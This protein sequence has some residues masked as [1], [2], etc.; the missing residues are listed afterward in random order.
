MISISEKQNCSGCHA[1]ASICPKDCIS[2]TAD[3]EGFWYP[4]VDKSKCI[5][6][7][8]CEKACSI[9]NPLSSKSNPDAYACYNKDDEIRMQSSSGGVFTLFAEYVIQQGGVLFGAVFDDDFNVIHSFIGK[10]QDLYKFRC[11]KYVQSKIGG[12]YSQAKDF[13]E[14]GKKVLFTG[15]PCQ[16]A[17]LKAY[18]S[19][20]YVNLICQDI[21]CHGVPSPKVWG[22]YLSE[23]EKRQQSSAK[24]I[25]FRNKQDGWQNYKLSISFKN[26][27]TYMKPK[28]SY[29]MAFL[30]NISLRPSCYACEFKTLN[31]LS[32][33]T[34]ADFWGIK[35]IMPEMFDDK[36]VSLVLI[37]SDKGEAVFK[38]IS[39]K[40]V[41]K[42][43]N[44]NEA[45]K[46]NPSAIQSS[47]I[48]PKRDY[49]FE[50]LEHASIDQL[51]KIC[52]RQ[53]MSIR[54]KN[55]GYH[56]GSKL[57]RMLIK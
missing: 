47:P 3:S 38:A 26:G 44:I 49:F 14:H 22:K 20:D 6:C 16:I 51:V 28:N 35:S 33:I 4:C 24:H 29:I 37:N 27:I 1:C 34:L 32:D 39:D 25:D 43:A 55:F 18:L 30:N 36:G 57:K 5:D 45:I 41:Y 53:S 7:G 21:I 11:S 2:I 31:R 8:L 13:L 56:V 12:T 50:N 42:E 9:I 40:L 52:C 23:C 15:T 10:E 17:G 46:N 48:H 19:K 54:I